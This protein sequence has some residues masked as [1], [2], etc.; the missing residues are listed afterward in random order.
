M[1][2]M[3]FFSVGRENM[4]GLFS[5][6]LTYL[7]ILIQF[8]QVCVDTQHHAQIP[9]SSSSFNLIRCVHILSTMLTYLI[10]LIQFD[11]VCADTQK[12]DHMF[13]QTQ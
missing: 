1:S 11:Q 3:G 12:L 13:A 6:M 9:T 8:D 2:A 4:V 7:I 10:I 5:T